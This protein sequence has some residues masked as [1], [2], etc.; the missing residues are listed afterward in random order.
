MGY[1][2]SPLNSQQPL[3]CIELRGCWLFIYLKLKVIFYRVVLGGS[4]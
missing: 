3:S 4:L 1:L 2:P